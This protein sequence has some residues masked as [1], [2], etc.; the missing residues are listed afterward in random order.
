MTVWARGSFARAILL[1]LL[2]VSIIPIIFIS[3]IFINQSTMALTNQMETNLY[4]LAQ[5]KAEEINLRLQE[6][7][8]A[9]AIAARESAYDMEREITPE[10]MSQKLAR[11]QTDSRNIFGLDMYYNSVG[12]ETTLGN[13][14]SNV[15]WNNDTAPTTKVLQDIALTEDMD[16]T[17]ASIK[18]I[19][20]QTQWIYMTT[21]EGMMRLYPWASNDHYPDG[22]DPR[23]V[24]FYTVAEP[25]NN[26]NL[27]TRW[28]PPYVD[29]AGAGWMVTVSTPIIS[30]DGEFEGI[31]SHD[32]T[33]QALKDIAL[34]I[35]VLD[36][37]G[38]GF[39]IDSEGGVIAH[40]A[41]EG[42]D[43][44][45]GT[46]E[47]VN[48]A[49]VGLPAFQELIQNMIDRESGQGYFL[50]ETGTQQL[51]VYAPIPSIGWSLG[52]SVPKSAVVA[53]ATAMRTRALLVA[54]VLVAAAAAVAVFL[55]R[56]LHQPLSRLMQ[57]VYAI[58]E[59]RRP[60]EIKVESFDE[61]MELANAFNDMADRVW[62]RESRLKKTVADLRIE[63]DAQ[64]SHKEVQEI[65]E[66][67]YFRQLELNAERMRNYVRRSR[68]KPS[69]PTL[70]EAPAV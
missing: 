33:I 30:S 14:L 23:E 44:S 38:Y 50:D 56:R 52:I 43:A 41:Y 20:P 25:T 35:N 22:W 4:M 51:L 63:I 64:R 49:T 62:E 34:D 13:G 5:S 42:V 21:P 17:F 60:E 45:K 61:L 1:A 37:A 65:T 19:S 28:T 55:A 58:A 66:T 27:E 47:T 26:P 10:E 2:F 59:E 68:G 69:S 46:Q 12:G 67:E 40:P 9:T 15:Y 53:P 29:F 48:L 18:A 54:V 7:W 32:V 3:V 57:G 39:I 11:Y 24:I 70:G 16:A 6:V 31:M 36:G 8:N